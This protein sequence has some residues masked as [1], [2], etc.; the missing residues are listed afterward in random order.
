MGNALRQIP[1][2]TSFL[3]STIPKPLPIPPLLL[4]LPP[5]LLLHTSSPTASITSS[6]LQP[7]RLLPPT[8][9][10]TAATTATLPR[11]LLLLPPTTTTTTTAQTKT[12]KTECLT[13]FDI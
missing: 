5:L 8:T 7:L 3:T 11:L 6:L 9:S 2:L 13:K 1:F 10:P 4:P 12:S